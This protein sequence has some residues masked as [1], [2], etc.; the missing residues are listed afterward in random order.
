MLYA[1]KRCNQVFDVKPTKHGK[2]KTPYRIM[3]YMPCD[4][5]IVKAEAF[6]VKNRSKTH[7]VFQFLA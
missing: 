6:K 1:C 3:E 4:G 2:A 7:Y 5:E